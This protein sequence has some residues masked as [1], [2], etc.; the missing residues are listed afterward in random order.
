MHAEIWLQHPAPQQAIEQW[1][2]AFCERRNVF[3][4][5]S[6]DRDVFAEKLSNLIGKLFTYNLT[7]KQRDLE[8]KNWLKLAPFNLSR[9]L[10]Q[11]EDASTTSK[12]RDFALCL[13]FLITLC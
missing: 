5:R 7:D 6:S 4:K 12:P 2:K 1:T 3:E 8:I 13:R 10:N 9:N 11:V